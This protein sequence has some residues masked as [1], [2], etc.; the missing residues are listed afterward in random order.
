MEK[1]M[2][3]H[4]ENGA[5]K[6]KRAIIAGAGKGIGE[7]IAYQFALDG[8]QV[9]LAARTPSDLERVAAVIRSAGGT[10]HCIP[11]DMGDVAQV[12]SLVGQ[13]AQLMGG[14]DVIV[15]NAAAVDSGLVADITL[16]LWNRVQ[17]VNVIGTLSL[18][19]AAYPHL[20][21]SPG[22][23]ALIISSIQSLLG[24]PGNAPY[25]A[26]K[27]A[28]NHLTRT[29]AVEWGPVGIRINAILPGP[30]FT[31]LMEQALERMP[32]LKVYENAAPLEG[33][34]LSED[35]ARPAS[36]LVSDAARKISGHLLVVD[37]ALSVY[38]QD[39]IVLRD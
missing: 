28:L 34:T 15:S 33:W 17:Q 2:V 6:G 24:V 16:E 9:V 11:T 5:L 4:N 19:K 20:C 26:S 39:C 29:L 3:K 8:A 38:N 13:S 25:G 35:I 22:S 7:A 21:A 18:F 1:G 31:P 37:G 36:F 27:A 10:A 14:I 32:A 30:V 12:N 23:S